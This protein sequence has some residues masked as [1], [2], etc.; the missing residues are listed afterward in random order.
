MHHALVMRYA[1]CGVKRKLPDLRN[2]IMQC[3]HME[4][5]ERL[6]WA[7]KRRGIRTARI[8]AERLGVPYGTY[9]GHENGSRGI[10]DS[11]LKAYAEAFRVPLTWLAFGEGDP[12]SH[13]GNYILEAYG[14]VGAGAE[15]IGFDDHSPG[16]PMAEYE[17]AFPVPPGTIAVVVRGDSMYPRYDDG[18]VIGYYRDG[19]PPNELI[20]KECILRLADGR[21]FVKK[22]RKGS[23]P[24][25]FN[26]ESVNAPLI[27]DVAVEWAAE[28]HTV[29]RAG[30]WNKHRNG[31]VND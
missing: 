14:Y 15:V 13:P 23:A 19:R 7:R 20:G 9:A 27:E 8:A 3:A 16:D 31:H 17:A 2:F 10:R 24:G 5:H 18:D 11:E 28:V 6:K 29:V 4:R 21:Y 12:D 25:F 1:L 22:I 26:L 30:Q